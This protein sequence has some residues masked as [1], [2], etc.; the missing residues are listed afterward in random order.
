MKRLMIR[1]TTLVLLQT[2]QI[3]AHDSAAFEPVRK[4]IQH[5]LRDGTIPS[6]AVAVAKDGRILW[7]ECFGWADRENKRRSTAHTAYNIA[8]VTKPVTA[9]AIMRL[10]QERK[11]GLDVPANEYLKQFQIV[12][13][14]GDSKGPS[15][16]Q[17]LMH[18]SGLPIHW[19]S[20]DLRDLKLRPPFGETA[21]R[22]AFAAWPP[23]ERYEY[24]N[25][26]YGVLGELIAQI[27]G[28]SYADFIQEEIFRPL[29]M[30]DSFIGLPKD[31]STAASPYD[32]G[33]RIELND[34]D[35]QGASAA[36]SS[37][38]DLVLFG[39][40]H[41]GT[42]LPGQEQILSQANIREMQNTSL[43]TN[44]TEGYGM[45]WSTNSDMLGVSIVFHG[46]ANP[47]AEASLLLVPSE[48]LVIAVLTNNNNS[49]PRNV[50]RE[51]IALLVPSFRA[52]LE[53][54][55]PHR[56]MIEAPSVSEPVENPA[57]ATPEDLLG[58]WT[59]KVRTYTG[60]VPLT[61]WCSKGGEVRLQLDDELESLVNNVD[62]KDG[63]GISGLAF[64]DIGTPDVSRFTSDLAID[65]TRHGD[66]MYGVLSTHEHHGDRLDRPYGELS[67][68]V[69][70]VRQR[71]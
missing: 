55:L 46:G 28:R 32:D 53:Q 44:G 49:M 62:F 19:Q 54:A 34:N 6:V 57:Q 37:V 36:Y 33:K 3:R 35:T 56:K 45:G 31:P 24:S 18:R 65:V 20:W 17:L 51:I 64:G 63:A 14:P 1:L 43:Q 13:F 16:R 10:A 42:L 48:K 5:E 68:F 7:E 26:G 12:S 4:Q 15:V 69:D 2:G 25:L 8:S 23:G 70:L 39:I 71:N 59:G 30:G 29:E 66:R 52:R 40:F 61:L 38:H 50:T 58:K 67:H 21:R 22:Y 11:V 27:S 9:T 47:G 41:L 60:E